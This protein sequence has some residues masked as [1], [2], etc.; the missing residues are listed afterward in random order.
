MAD[1]ID[2]LNMPDAEFSNQSAPS[3]Q[4]PPVQEEEEI[5]DTS[6][7]PISDEVEPEE[8]DDGSEELSQAEESETEEGTQD[9]GASAPGK[10][11]SA[12][13]EADSSAEKDPQNKEDGSEGNKP[14]TEP[15]QVNQG[16]A[17]TPEGHK[18]IYD[19]IMGSTI[20]AS[21]RDIKIRTPE[22]A[23]RL[24][25][26]GT[27][28]TKKMHQLHPAMRIVKMLDRNGLLDEQKLAHLVDLERGDTAAIQKFLADKKFDPHTVDETEANSYRPGNHQVSDSDLLFDSVLDDLESTQT[29]GELIREIAEQWDTQSKQHVYKEPTLLKQI[30]EQ[31]ADGTYARI[32]E[33]MERQKV[34]GNL[35]P[36]VPFLQAYYATGKMLADHGQL[37]AQAPVTPPAPPAPVPVATR[38]VTRPALPN[39]DKAR[40]AAS[41]RAAPTAPPSKI[42]YLEM[43]DAEFERQMRPG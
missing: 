8:P 35:P 20:R 43:S 38:T 3:P 10:S 25:Q 16:L 32:V 22:E 6:A 23:V 14:N 28:Y 30:N 11:G 19:A 5:V 29:G 9:E 40:A 27:D 18:A 39:G 34:F 7:P 31:K 4:A 13:P 21:G 42:N 12:D 41:V 15:T 33:E 2:Y 36:G 1:E 24:I 17:D 26:M 37:Q